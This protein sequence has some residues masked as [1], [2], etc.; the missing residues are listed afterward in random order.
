MDIKKRIIV[1]VSNDITTDQRVHKVCQ[2]L[3]DLG[4]DVLLIGRKLKNSLELE[5]RDYKCKRIKL[6]FNK[7]FLF[8]LNLNLRLFF[9]LLFKKSH[10][11]LS[12]DLDT[13][14]ANYSVSKIRNSKLYYDSHELFTEV[15]E[16]ENRNFVKNIW[17]KI[18]KICFRKIF[19]AY[20]VCDS[21][22]DF[23]NNKYNLDFKVIRNLPYYNHE[24]ISYDKR[25]NIIIYQG[26]LNKDR[27]LE[28]MI[29]SMTN[30]NDY[31]LIIVG[32]GDIEN[33][34]KKLTQELNLDDKVE[35]KGQ[36]KYQDLK[37]FTQKSKLGLSLERNTNLNYYY[38][39]PNKVFDYINCGTPVLCSDFPEMSKII[40]DYN[41]GETFSGS[42]AIELGKVIS[43]ILGNTEK[44]QKYH[45]NCEAASKELCWEKEREK[46]VNLY[47]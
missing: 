40:N 4:Y 13:L 36:L 7:G 2:T 15:P 41:V 29:E 45:E 32:K 26:A 6:W 19:K 28:I 20:T 38:S 21:I 24:S 8:Y 16:L 18:E 35:F 39:L 33:Y 1:S 25:D 10:Y 11:L 23:Y 30:I 14:L 43:D 44:M 12:N 34:L 5:S 17:L 42:N 47:S 9:I 3:F 31:K 22:A 46:L 27:G 37:T